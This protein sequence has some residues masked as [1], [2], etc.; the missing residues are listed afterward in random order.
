MSKH[1]TM[2]ERA[3]IEKFLAFGFNF[4]A[5]AEKLN[6][7]PSTISREVKKYRLFTT[8]ANSHS[9]NG[10]ARYFDCTRNAVCNS[11]DIGCFVSCKKCHKHD[12][13]TIC[14]SYI[15]I[16]CKK[17]E[18]PPYVCT[19]CKK[20]QSCIKHHAYYSSRRAHTEYLRTLSKSRTGIRA[21]PKELERISSIITPLILKGQSINQIMANHS[22][23]I[24]ISEKC[25]YNYID[26]NVFSIRNLDL[27]K[28]VAYR[29]RRPAVNLTRA[30][31]KY[32]KGRSY[33][34]FLQHIKDNPNDSIVEMDTVKGARN[35]GK[36]LL[37]MI[38]RKT[39]F[40]LIFLMPDATMQSVQT[41]F[42]MLTEKL[43]IKLFRKLFRVILTDN[44][45]EFKDPDSL[46]YAVNGCARTKIFYCDP[47]AS[48]QKP[49]VEKN[50]ELIR[51]IL[52]KK[53]S[54]KNLTRNDIHAVC[55]HINSV[56]RELFDNK[57][58]FQLMTGKDNEKLLETL[59]LKPIPPDKV[60]LKP[61]LIN[62]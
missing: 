5:I 36:V 60:F 2:S 13:T 46:E 3:L 58:P 18:K 52:P 34:N 7:S 25:L 31:Y 35:S 8:R 38:F 9:E 12:C 39:N 19:G 16:N 33:E 61:A 26:S 11:K 44:G 10:C 62:N 29:Q 20:Q 14:K 24:G 32:R 17:L 41:I 37:T 21:T 57:T 54:F 23:E 15:P 45:S 49:H 53:T 42:D 51:R 56:P 30:E 6:R 22:E 48:W 50:H 27:P 28:K 4:S 55:C 43:G 1:M 47:Q 59:R 40:M